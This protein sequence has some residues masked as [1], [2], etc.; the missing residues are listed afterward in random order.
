VSWWTYYSA[1]Q[2]VLA[3]SALIW[4]GRRL[5]VLLFEAPLDAASFVPALSTALDAGQIALAR[6]L[7][8]ACEPAWPAHLARLALIEVEQGRDPRSALDETY[9]DLEAALWRGRDAIVVLGRMATPVAFIGVIVQSG[10]ALGGGEGLAGLQRGLP[11]SIALQRSL[12][13]FSVGISTTIVC[14]TA[15]AAIQRQARAL[16]R[17]LDRVARVITEPRGASRNEM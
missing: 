16:R 8:T 3:V 15:A 12:L 11:A 6:S 14:L 7:A 4:I 1:L 17:D 9:A 5:R 10:I 2:W 13:A